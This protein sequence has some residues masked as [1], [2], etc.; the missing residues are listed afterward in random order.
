M[1]SGSTSPSELLPFTKF[2][3]QD[4]VGMD[5]TTK[6]AHQ[7]TLDSSKVAEVDTAIST[8]SFVSA[9]SWGNEDKVDFVRLQDVLDT[10]LLDRSYDEWKVA[11]S[12][13]DKLRFRDFR[14]TAQN[15]RLSISYAIV[16]LL[17][18]KSKAGE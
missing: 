8:Q 3:L 14:C 2:V 1:T 13:Y 7:K 4:G 11:Q 17:G 18:A 5:S 10:S 9:R 12:T 6:S 15:A 16:E